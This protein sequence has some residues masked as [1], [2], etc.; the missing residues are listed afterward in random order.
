MAH[1]KNG[2][3]KANQTIT[4][5]Q[6]N[7]V[8][9]SAITKLV[10]KA[11]ETLNNGNQAVSEVVVQQQQI[12]I[13]KLLARV[14]KLEERVIALEGGLASVNHVTSVLQE[15]LTAKKNHMNY[16]C[17]QEGL[18]SSLPVYVKKKTRI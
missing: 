12:T 5:Q 10:G 2:K 8:K 15:L 6:K 18:V 3:L 13:D 11:A 14:V 16:K 9:V 4:L 1:K 7:D 17:T